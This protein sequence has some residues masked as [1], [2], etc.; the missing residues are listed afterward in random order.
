MSSGPHLTDTERDTIRRLHADGLSCTKVAAELGRSRSTISQAAK[1]MG[2]S[3]DNAQ[4]KAA[5][6][7]KQADN[8]SK[9]AALESRLLD[10]AA[11]LLDQLHRPH[12][13]YSFGGRDNTYAD[14][15]L[16]EPDVGA[17]R[18]LIQAAGTAIDKSL[19]IAAVDQAT[20]GADAGRSMIGSLFAALSV[21]PVG[22]PETDGTPATE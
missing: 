14:H 16:D 12:L 2:L 3:W 4:T 9:R 1:A 13:V 10:E 22:D 20:T 19:R 11:G 15:L 5:T 17:K 8:R 6:A 21:T 7:A 18:A